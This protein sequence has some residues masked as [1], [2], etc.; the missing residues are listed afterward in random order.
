MPPIKVKNAGKSPSAKRKSG[1]TGKAVTRIQREKQDAILEAA[2]DVFSLHGF[3]GATIDQIAEQAGMSKPNLLYYFPRKEEIHKRLM[4]TMLDTWLQ[5]L[6]EFSAEG[7]PIPEIRSYIRR[8]LEMARD[9]PRESRL[10]ANEMLQGAPRLIDILEGELKDLVD[11]KAA[12]LLAWMDEGKIVRT[13]PYH[14]IF[15]IWATTQH[16]ADFDVQVRA[17]LGKDR[18]GEG[19]FEDAAR[20]LESLFMSGIAPRQKVS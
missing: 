15:S 1:V 20:F 11:E 10:F 19:R 8:K 17:V 6:R 12:I 3:R 5:P 16:Y 13:D 4:K 7:D 14:L 2:L 9:F 18:G